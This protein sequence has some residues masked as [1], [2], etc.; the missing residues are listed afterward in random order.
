VVIYD[1]ASNR[2]GFTDPK[3]GSTTNAYDTL[4]RL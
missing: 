3:G 2:T 4:N 1:A